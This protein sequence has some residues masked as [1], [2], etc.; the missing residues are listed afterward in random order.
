M[1]NLEPTV[2]FWK[3]RVGAAAGDLLGADIA[4]RAA[5]AALDVSYWTLAGGHPQAG[6]WVHKITDPA[7]GSVPNETNLWAT[8]PPAWG[9]AVDSGAGFVGNSALLQRDIIQGTMSEFISILIFNNRA[10]VGIAPLIST[11]ENCFLRVYDDPTVITQT[12]EPMVPAV[13]GLHTFWTQ[14][15]QRGY[16][17]SDGAGTWAKDATQMHAD[18]TGPFHIGNDAGNQWSAGLPTPNIAVPPFDDVS[19]KNG[20]GFYACGSGS[21]IGGPGGY[22]SDKHL[23]GCGNAGDP[24]LDNK[25]AAIEL[26]MRLYVPDTATAKALYWALAIEYTFVVE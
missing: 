1:A 7:A 20:L 6:N 25:G 14:L 19:A 5:D 23:L 2:E 24:L 3:G 11:A 4:A 15:E 12:K 18:Y 9:G 10:E 16:W 8:L 21:G 26:S 13:G 17:L 22:L